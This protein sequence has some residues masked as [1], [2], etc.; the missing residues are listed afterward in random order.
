MIAFF[1]KPSS[2]AQGDWYRDASP[3]DRQEYDAF[4][5]WLHAVRSPVDMPPRFLPW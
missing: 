3:A 1:R 4:G 5:P 2:A